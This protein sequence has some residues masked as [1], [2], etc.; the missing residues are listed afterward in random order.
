CEY[1]ASIPEIEAQIERSLRLAPLSMIIAASSIGNDVDAALVELE[2]VHGDSFNGQLLYN[3]IEFGL[4]GAELGCVGCHDG[5][6]APLAEGTWT[7]V[8]E[9]RLLDP[10]F[11][12]YDVARY[13]V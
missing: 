13:L 11:E 2:T 4:D 7:R 12:G 8:D 9:I 5:T 6:I 1:Q 3:G 10:Q